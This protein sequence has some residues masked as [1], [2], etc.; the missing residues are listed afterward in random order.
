MLTRNILLALL[1]LVMWLGFPVKFL[2]AD[3]PTELRA[4][5]LAAH[6]TTAYTLPP[7]KLRQAVALTRVRMTFA[8]GGTAWTFAQVLLILSLGIASRMDRLATHLTK[9]RFA[10][11]F[12]FLFCLLALT[13]LLDLPLAL[14]GHHISLSYGL[15]IQNWPSWFGDLA[16]SFALEW[17]V[18][19]LLLTVLF[20]IVRKSPNRWWFWFWI[21]TVALSILGV[22]LTPYVIDPIFNKFEPLAN[23]DP[24]LV[25]RLEQVVARSGIAIPPERM[26]L[27]K[28]SA[29]S[30]E[31]NAY[32]TGFGASKRVV[33]WDT[34]IAKSTPDEI[35][36]I[37]GHE[38]GHYALGH[39]ASTVLFV[40]AMLLPLFWLG[41][42]GVRLILARFG[43]AWGIS[44][45]NDW[46]AAV[47]FALVLFTLSFLSDPIFNAFS[48]AHE[49]AADVYGQ[50]A[51]HGI[52]ADPQ[53]I[54]RQSFQ[55][56]GETSL[57]DPTP[58]PLF[59]F[60]FGTHPPIRT[61]AAFAQLYNPWAAGSQPRYFTH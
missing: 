26:I 45:Q 53:S 8:I 9:F 59:E 38:L 58:H 60:W 6:D 3:T 46:A 35:A 42:H 20:W 47:V 29:K 12:V 27:M 19:G 23:S 49:H 11:G 32:V 50:E 16:K 28:A 52:V 18:G 51:V 30:T 10:Q 4:Q 1:T 17:L 21:P 56:L 7:E 48:R 37:F 13:G 22:F 15:S 43:S 40:S 41:F 25:S 44:S 2:A 55:V 24:A 54:G 57:D 31:L 14:Y 61:R 36:L 33:V 5:Q 34:T 39:I